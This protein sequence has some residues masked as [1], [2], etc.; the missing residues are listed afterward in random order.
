MDPQQDA[1][2]RAIFADEA[3][4][5][6]AAIADGALQLEAGD[7]DAEFLAAL[8]RSAHSLKGAAA[9]MGFVDIGR[10]AHVLED[11]LDELRN[12]QRSASPALTDA[13]INGVDTLRKMLPILLAGE[14]LGDVAALAEVRLRALADGEIDTGPAPEATPEPEAEPPPGAEAKPESEPQARRATDGQGDIIRIPVERLDEMVHVMGEAMAAQL[15]LGRWLSRRHG[16]EPDSIPEF[17][18]LSRLLSELQE[19]GTRTRMVSV[20]TIAG[21]LEQAVRATARSAGK[22]VRWEISGEQTELD[23]HV[24]EQLREALVHIVRNA[25][26]HGI[27]LPDERRA[28]GKPETG[29]VRLSAS[30]IGADIVIVLSDD[31]K[32]ID[33]DAIRGRAGADAGDDLLSFIFQSGFSTASS[34]TDVSGRGVGLD[35]VRS[36]IEHVRGRIDVSSEPGAGVEFRITVPITLAVLPSLIVRADGHSYAVP[37]HSTAAVGH[38]SSVDEL[39]VEG[40]SAVRIGGQ[41]YPVTSLSSILGL[42]DG[43]PHGPVLVLAGTSRRHAVRVDALVERRDVVVSELSPVLGRI[44]LFSG[45]S[46]EADGSVLLVLD[47][48]AVVDAARRRG[49]VKLASLA[50]STTAPAAKPAHAHVLIV[51]DALTIRELQRSILERAGYEVTLAGDGEEALATLSSLSTDLVLS[52]VEMPKMGGLALTAAIRE[53]PQLRSLPVILVTSRDSDE[54]RRRGLEAGA[55][56]YIIKS[57]FDEGQLLEV[58][59]RVL[60]KAAA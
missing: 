51:D 38:P 14:P 1:E 53:H 37:I 44:D 30:Q 24:L 22:Q 34:V 6:L 50:P 29:V 59:E 28:A 41:L 25:V 18:Q 46:V 45:V 55:D 2:F 7:T 43:D 19:R 48:G 17:R 3:A 60:G 31:G 32:G 23:R 56:A 42:G 35:V 54:D 16:E 13:L 58:V 40:G 33:F 36:A 20:A 10:V 21:P 5:Q 4:E 26:D 39:A 27:E 52:D 57:A 8:F 49:P 11:L 47:P 15:R 9:V 12:G